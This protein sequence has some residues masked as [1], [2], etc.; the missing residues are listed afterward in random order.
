VSN[1][2]QPDDDRAS[3]SRLRDYLYANGPCSVVEAATACDLSPSQVSGLLR[4]GSI[5]PAG[6][7]G[8]GKRRC[9]ICHDPA[10]VNDLCL[11]CHRG[12]QDA[13]RP[14]SGSG[15]RTRGR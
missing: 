4:E 8:P 12:F 7:A 3:L 11:D 9:V 14:I 1:P 15:M 13:R 5:A 10:A 6:P 2:F